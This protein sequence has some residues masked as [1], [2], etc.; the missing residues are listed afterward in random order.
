[1]LSKR[2]VQKLFNA[3]VDECKNNTCSTCGC[4][5]QCKELENEGVKIRQ[6]VKYAQRDM[7]ARKIIDYMFTGKED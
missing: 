2:D 5:S 3:Y 1:M 4:L 6:P 7:K